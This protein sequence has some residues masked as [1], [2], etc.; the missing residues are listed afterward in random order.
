MSDT[1]ELDVLYASMRAQHMRETQAPAVV[2]QQGAGSTS[3]SHTHAGRHTGKAS[4]TSDWGAPGGHRSKALGAAATSLGGGGG[5]WDNDDA[6]E[7]LHNARW[8]GGSRQKVPGSNAFSARQSVFERLS[9]PRPKSRAAEHTANIV[10]ALHDAEGS[11]VRQAEVLQRK[12]DVPPPISARWRSS[13]KATSSGRGGASATGAGAS[14][15]RPAPRGGGK[16][17]HGKRTSMAGTP[18]D[19]AGPRGG[20]ASRLEHIKAQWR[21]LQEQGTVPSGPQ[22]DLESLLLA[23]E[24]DGDGGDST[25]RLL[26]ALQGTP[27]VNASGSAL[28]PKRPGVTDSTSSVHESAPLRLLRSAQMLS[29]LERAERDGYAPRGT[30][31]VALYRAMKRV[32]RYQD[33]RDAA[34]ALHRKVARMAAAGQ[35]PLHMKSL[36]ARLTAAFSSAE[37]GLGGAGHARRNEQWLRRAAAAGRPASPVAQVMAGVRSAQHGV[38][39]PYTPTSDASRPMDTPQ[40]DFR[41][42]PP[43]EGAP[44]PSDWALRRT[45]GGGEQPHGGGSELPSAPSAPLAPVPP[46]RSGNAAQ[47][48][49]HSST[50]LQGRVRLPGRSSNESRPQLAVSVPSASTAQ[51]HHGSSSSTLDEPVASSLYTDNSTTFLTQSEGVVEGKQGGVHVP[52]LDMSAMRLSTSASGRAPTSMMSLT[53]AASDESALAALPP[54]MR[55]PAHMRPTHTGRDELEAAL[56]GGRTL[57]AAIN[58]RKQQ[59]QPDATEVE[60]AVFRAGASSTDGLLSPRAAKVARSAR[61]RTRAWAS[62]RSSM[63]DTKKEDKSKRLEEHAVDSGGRT[64]A[65]AYSL[66]HHRVLVRAAA[67]SGIL[68]VLA[69]TRRLAAA[70]REA[71][72]ARSRGRMLHRVV[73]AIQVAWK[74]FKVKRNMELVRFSAQLRSETAASIVYTTLRE[75]NKHRGGLLVVMRRF[76]RTVVWCQRYWGSYRLLGSSRQLLL[77]S[78]WQ[79]LVDEIYAAMVHRAVGQW[80]NNTGG[81][82]ATLVH[83]VQSQGKSDWKRKRILAKQAAAALK[84]GAPSMSLSTLHQ[85][86]HRGVV[87]KSR[88][89]PVPLPEKRIAASA[90]ARSS[91][92]ARPKWGQ[93]PPASARPS[94]AGSIGGANVATPRMSRVLRALTAG[95]AVSMP[96]PDEEVTVVEG[97]SEV[98]RRRRSNAAIIEYYLQPSLQLGRGDRPTDTPLDR[99]EHALEAWGI[100]SLSRMQLA[101]LPPTAQFRSRRRRITLLQRAGGASGT[102][103][104]K[105]ISSVLTFLPHELLP[106]LVA[107]VA[108]CSGNSTAA[109]WNDSLWDPFQLPTLRD[110]APYLVNQLVGSQLALGMH[111]WVIRMTHGGGGGAGG[112]SPR[113]S[114]ALSLSTG[115]ALSRTASRRGRDAFTVLPLQEVEFHAGGEAAV[116]DR[117]RRLQLKVMASSHAAET[118]R[119]LSG[120]Q[121]GDGQASATQPSRGATYDVRLGRPMPSRAVL[122]Q[123]H[124]AVMHASVAAGH[125]T[126]SN[127]DG[128]RAVLAALQSKA[129]SPPSGLGHTTAKP[130]ARSRPSK[131]VSVVEHFSLMS[132][133][134]M[135]AALRAELEHQEQNTNDQH[136]VEAVDDMQAS[137][138]TAGPVASAAGSRVAAAAGASKLGGTERQLLHSPTQ[139]HVDDAAKQSAADAVTKNKGDFNVE[140][141]AA[142]LSQGRFTTPSAIALPSHLRVLLDSIP[143]HMRPAAPGPALRAKALQRAVRRMRHAHW[144]GALAEWKEAQAERKAPPSE[145]IAGGGLNTEEDPL[146]AARALLNEDAAATRLKAEREQ[147]AAALARTKAPPPL[148]LLMSTA[149]RVVAHDI[150]VYLM[151]IGTPIQDVVSWSQLSERTVRAAVLAGWAGYNQQLHTATSVHRAMYTPPL[152][153]LKPP[154]ARELVRVTG[155]MHSRLYG[156]AAPAQ[157]NSGDTRSSQRPGSASAAGHAG[158]STLPAS[159]VDGSGGG[160]VAESKGARS[161]RAPARRDAP[162]RPDAIEG[163]IEAM[164]RGI[165]HMSESEPSPDGGTPRSSSSAAVSPPPPGAASTRGGGF[166]PGNTPIPSLSTNPSAASLGSQSDAAKRAASKFAIP[167]LGT[168]ESPLAR[169]GGAA[170]GFSDL[171]SQAQVQALAPPTGRD[172]V[173][174]MLRPLVVASMRS[175][176]LYW[177]NALRRLRPVKAKVSDHRTMQFD[178]FLDELPTGDS[179]L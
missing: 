53:T 54:G 134:G 98:T 10:Q 150:S 38:P 104:V 83:I 33:S 121:K 114:A 67:W 57:T 21:A 14:H 55:P 13:L 143:L 151:R 109:G 101:Q 147:L 119:K 65:V 93:A 8:A 80:E 125:G 111:D 122:K 152:P 127:D 173:K 71:M 171:L 74:R 155:H 159:R 161:K 172:A 16:D 132:E 177:R 25:A 90:S 28:P 62:R 72:T 97:G 49:S 64:I 128:M 87:R 149:R 112:G 82:G 141:A 117:V 157:A 163:A 7:Q 135:D 37:L 22:F 178:W 110:A 68:S 120:A 59:Q 81:K 166:H 105:R 24:E 92:A 15:P 75:L 4:T 129:G 41:P 19:D 145:G 17:S 47:G 11:R 39:Q 160:G 154:T 23:A 45:Q 168:G 34:D 115:R 136:T 69:R 9:Q 95:V 46:P 126:S 106:L 169:R 40:A 32:E 100:D 148:M 107:P 94:S 89:A 162:D 138:Q 31:E 27:A 58:S 29:T 42:A 76:H 91:A 123:L 77:L 86:R 140:H 12:L 165:M 63:Q 142:A 164:S 35:I 113:I 50:Q 44:P 175:A 61:A 176:M 156:G 6:Q 5:L 174:A 3:A 70:H 84:G 43:V 170:V 18:S 51:P 96:P 78:V 85:G 167:P 88:H 118:T 48:G 56:S 52:R 108:A 36:L 73:A 20:A 103:L 144:R 124:S 66:Q 153:K 30:H 60:Q 139:Q 116:L 102:R 2:Q 179:G 1:D 130:S 26:H 79:E 137:K 131:T 133:R 158:S 146:A 99:A